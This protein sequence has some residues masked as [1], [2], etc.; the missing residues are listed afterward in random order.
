MVESKRTKKLRQIDEVNQLSY[1]ELK[2]LYL[3]DKDSFE[4]WASDYYDIFIGNNSYQLRAADYY[5]RILRLYK[6]GIE[7]YPSKKTID[8]TSVMF[9]AMAYNR[10][11]YRIRAD[12]D[13]TDK[14]D[15]QGLFLDEI[16][17]MRLKKHSVKYE[18]AITEIYKASLDYDNRGKYTVDDFSS[19][20]SYALKTQN[21]PFVVQSMIDKYRM[22]HPLSRRCGNIGFLLFAN[23]VLTARK[24]EVDDEFIKN[25]R[26]IIDMSHTVASIDGVAKVDD[27]YERLARYTLRLI[28][29][30]EKDKKREAS[31]EKREQKRMVKTIFKKK[32]SR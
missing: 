18:D 16:G 2:E 28:N 19:Y 1:E 7:V 15:F 23:Y 9:E 27:D 32:S 21:D 20:I 10:S 30:F 22:D 4:K 12:R 29:K 8:Y 3:K 17:V 6:E 5:D 11:K 26:G 14:N 31:K 13:Q 24:F 25:V